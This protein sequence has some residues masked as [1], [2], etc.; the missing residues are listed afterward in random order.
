MIQPDQKTDFS[1]WEDLY[2]PHHILGS[3]SSSLL[4]NFNYTS[5]SSTA[6]PINGYGSIPLE[7]SK[8]LFAAD[9]IAIVSEMRLGRN[10]QS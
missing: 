8:S 10:V 1:S 2:G 3:S 9:N 4:A 5:T 7:P 6:F